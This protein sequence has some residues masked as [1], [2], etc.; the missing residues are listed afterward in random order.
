MKFRH[1]FGTSVV[2]PHFGHVLLSIAIL[3]SLASCS[4]SLRELS[5]TKSGTFLNLGSRPTT[6]EVLSPVEPVTTKEFVAPAV[7]S[8]FIVSPSDALQSEESGP[9]SGA[10]GGTDA[11]SEEVARENVF[12]FR[13][14]QGET[15]ALTVSRDGSRAFSGGNDGSIVESRLSKAPAKNKDR[16]HRL[17]VSTGRIFQAKKPVLALSLSPDERYLAVAQFS[18]V[19]VIDLSSKR[20]AYEMT[21]ISGRILSLAWDPRGE[22]L[23][24][25]RAN[26]DIFVWNLEPGFLSTDNSLEA[27][28]SYSGAN[29]PIVRVVFHPSSRALFSAEQDGV[30]SLW[31]LLRTE[32]ELGLRDD[33]AEVDKALKGTRSV[34]VAKVSGRIEDLWL[35][36]GGKSLFVSGQD[37]AVYRWKIRGLQRIG[38]LKVGADSSIS[39][40]GLT[41]PVSAE[42]PIDTAERVPLLVTT[43]RSQRI[44]VWCQDLAERVG[45]SGAV[46]IVSSRKEEPVTD[47]LSDVPEIVDGQLTVP[48]SPPTTKPS[49]ESKE[50]MVD[51]R[52]LLAQSET[53]QNPIS[54]LR[55]GTDS[56]VLWGIE[57][58]GNL[59]IFDVSLLLKSKRW[60]ALAD[61]CGSPQ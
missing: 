25:G 48:S 53:L 18:A 34:T 21:Q 29:S 56:P 46:P 35:S 40:I 28:E 58:T 7:K 50:G 57:K 33:Y 10:N 26:G 49:P 17:Q 47:V 12:V 19:T 20:V 59:A 61:R 36:P 8:P 51:S 55:S 60:R 27:I 14:H 4:K 44:K 43:G 54:L 2:R 13:A 15:N 16:I 5:L 30:V 24:F 6:S 22:L 37:G 38:A 32:R 52:Y 3:F 9:N 41:L 1:L 39:L 31:R 42:L 23:A 11:I 45:R